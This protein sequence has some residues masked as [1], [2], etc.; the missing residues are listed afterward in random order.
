MGSNRDVI[1]SLVWTRCL[2]DLVDVVRIDAFRSTRENARVVDNKE[3]P[4]IIHSDTI[5]V[6][7]IAPLV[8]MIVL[9]VS[10]CVYDE[11][12]SCIHQAM[13]PSI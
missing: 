7:S 8:V 12:K 1:C 4:T 5:H 13:N 11:T 2:Q 3:E 6:H 9:D 10:F